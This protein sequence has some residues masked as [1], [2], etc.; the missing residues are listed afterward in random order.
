MTRVSVAL[1]LCGVLAVAVAVAAPVKTVPRTAEADRLAAQALASCATAEGAAAGEAAARKALL[2]TNEFEPTD[3]VGMGRKGEVVEDEFLEAR[4]VYRSHRA[5]VYEALGTCLEQK[6][7]HRPAARYLGRAALLEPSPQRA[8]ALARALLAEERV[9]EAMAALRAVLRPQA[10]PDPDWLRMVTLAVDTAKQASVQA[11]LDRW[12]VQ[13]LALPNLSH[14]EGPVRAGAEARLSTGAPFA[15]TDEPLLLYVSSVSCKDCSTQLQELTRTVQEFRR[16]AAKDGPRPEVRA[17]MVPEVPDQ[18]H[19]LRQVMTIYRYDFPVLLGRGHAAALAAPAGSVLV[20]A[21][22]G[23]SAA[24]VRPPY[25]D[26]LASAL[27]VLARRDV[28]ESLPRTAASRRMADAAPRAD[29]L[30][31][32]GLAPGEDE[33]A[34]ASFT[35]AL[36]AYRAGKGL[37][38]IRFLDALGDDP[39]GWLLPPEARFDRALA[40]AKLGDRTAAR[41][42]LLRIGDSRF[43]QDVDRVLESLPTR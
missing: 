17:F 26:A 40:L 43:Q 18:D 5:R 34:P 22:R 11:Q 2:L 27:D 6:A 30:P 41:R 1:C 12:R 19:A 3:F 24:L 25:G 31:P 33:P 9:P 39:G 37:E 23:W 8:V 10:A 32:D 20:V 13:A 29:T 35:A 4:R 36:D 7:S 42:I 15:W 28:S 21:R 14:V 16:G 38:T